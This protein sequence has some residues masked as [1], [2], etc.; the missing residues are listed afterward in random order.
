MAF[1]GSNLKTVILSANPEI[2]TSLLKILESNGFK[3]V[4]VLDNGIEALKWAQEGKFE[5]VICDQNIKFIKGWLFIK[6]LKTSDQIPNLPIVFFGEGESPAT[7]DDYK[8]FG[9]VNYLQYPFRDTDFSFMVNSTLSLFR[10][11]GT[12]E[13]KFTKAKVAVM[14]NDIKA[15]VEMYEELHGLTKKN[16]RSSLGLADVY[17]KDEQT[18]KA[19][20]VVEQALADGDLSPSQMMMSIKVFL[21]KKD[22]E[23]STEATQNMLT[24]AC[25][26]LPFYFSR[27]LKLHME[28]LSNKCAIWV[29]KTAIAKK[30]KIPDFK[31]SLARLKFDAGEFNDAISCIKD[32]E[33][34]YG[35]SPD[36]LN[37]KGVALKKV[38]DLDGAVLAYEE[39]LKLSPMDHK[40]YYNLAICAIASKR[41]EEA[42]S[43]LNSC[44]RINPSFTRAQEKLDE[45]FTKI[46]DLKVGNESTT[47]TDALSA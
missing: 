39:A 44:V 35:V 25:A 42:V 2:S 24:H 26:D 21:S 40:I 31:I 17:I 9:V 3:N 45:I 18:D 13:D 19:A 34:E 10:T 28:Y 27:A 36:L 1:P 43:R 6:E 4:M 33:K 14:K 29:C 20:E 8:Q 38:G 5:L 15:A 22:F 30:F 7:P 46:P 41:F 23:K 47:N 32:A 12:I 11:S 37:I 16:S